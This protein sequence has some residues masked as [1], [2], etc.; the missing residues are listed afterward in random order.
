MPINA[1]PTPESLLEEVAALDRCL[2]PAVGA[3][4]FFDERGRSLGGSRTRR[5][6]QAELTLQR[7]VHESLRQDA[8]VFAR[9][10][11]TECIAVIRL[12]GEA[13]FATACAVS[14]RLDSNASPAN[15]EIL[16]KRLLA[17]LSQGISA[18]GGAL[19]DTDYGLAWGMATRAGL[20]RQVRAQAPTRAGHEEC[21]VLCVN[22]DRLHLVNETQGFEAGDRLIIQVAS[23]LQ[24]PLLPSEAMSA[25]LSGGE[26]AVV[27]PRTPC[28]QAAPVAAGI[29]Q[30][31]GAL[32]RKHATDGEPVSI[33]CGIA[34]FQAPGDFQ[35]A[36]ACAQ[37]ACR[38]A[39]DR[40]R[41]RVQVFERTDVSMIGRFSDGLNLQR[42]RDALRQE[43]HLVLFAQKIISIQ[44]HDEPFGYEVLLRS[45]ESRAENVAPA[46]LLATAERNQMSSQLDLWVIEHA[47]AQA[48][49]YRAE[50]ASRRTWLSLNVSGPSLTDNAFVDRVHSL[51]CDSGLSPALVT[52]EII[53]SAAVSVRR[54]SSCIGKMR[55]LGYRFALD[56]F[57]IGN[58]SLKILTSLPIHCVKIDGSFVRDILVNLQSE[59]TVRAIVSLA[60]DLGI[61]TIAEYAENPAIIER[62][63][64]LR[65]DYVQGYGVAHPQPFDDVLSALGNAH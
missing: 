1:E 7:C 56:D 33:S 9:T 27:L 60:K 15:V 19:A 36:L 23:L 50:L 2:L 40:G 51:V 4:A 39:Q 42:L 34:A 47:I 6:P 20:E 52:F 58:N 44:G 45:T 17:F 22:I 25:H 12:R 48:T 49:R 5:T 30:A 54:A 31:A 55:E 29:Q 64:E 43:G 61:S 57:G 65:V 24:G 13:S 3:C 28:E 18:L 14:F 41:G 26:F 38:T 8:D 21:S 63:G 59:A 37:L 46:D 16:G 35:Q 53:E 32:R 62:L 11:P 10:S